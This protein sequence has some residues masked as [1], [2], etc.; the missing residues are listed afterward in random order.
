M[1]KRTILL[2]LFSA[3]LY[4]GDQAENCGCNSQYNELS[5]TKKFILY[6]A[7][8]TGTVAATIAAAPVVLPA[9]AVAAVTTALA[10][11]KVAIAAGAAKAAAAITTMGK[12][13]LG[14]SAAQYARPYILRT[15]EE[16]RD[17][18]LKEKPL[19]ALKAEREFISCLKQN[20]IGSS[21]NSTGRPTACED[22][23]LFYALV[24]GNAKLNRRTK[25]FNDKKCFC[26]A[27]IDHSLKIDDDNEL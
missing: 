25:A 16:K 8:G 5:K 9:G 14:L 23:A 18:L 21:K 2:L 7:I 13:S 19:K 20:K 10:S 15:T 3:N 11:A 17:I 26:Y 1:L 27:D 6:G 4:A 22:V 24:A 12:V